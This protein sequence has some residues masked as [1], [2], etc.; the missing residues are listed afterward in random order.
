MVATCALLPC[1]RRSEASGFQA[2]HGDPASQACSVG[3]VGSLEQPEER[4]RGYRI[5]QPYYHAEGWL[6]TANQLMGSPE[7]WVAVLE[8]RLRVLNELTVPE[9]QDVPR[10]ARAAYAE[11]LAN[12]VLGIAYG[13]QEL[14]V[15]LAHRAHPLLS[16]PMDGDKRRKVGHGALTCT[17]L[18]VLLCLA[19]GMFCSAGP[20]CASA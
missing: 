19:A 4:G 10:R 8:G 9:E 14:A 18:L 2:Q 15:R 12:M 6:R 1:L 3:P 16:T 11:M 17:A 13:E 5:Y 20:V 7:A